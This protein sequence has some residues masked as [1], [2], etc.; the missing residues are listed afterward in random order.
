M[1][2]GAILW[3]CY[4]VGSFLGR[5]GMSRVYG[6]VRLADHLPVALKVAE[7]PEDGGI[8]AKEFRLLRDLEHSGVVKVLEYREMDGLWVL[9]ME[10]LEGEDL[11]RKKNRQEYFSTEQIRLWGISLICIL[12]YLHERGICYLDL[13]PA[14]VMCR[15][16]GSLV[17]VDF[18]AA[19][20]RKETEGQRLGT[21]GYAAP[22]QLLGRGGDWRSDMYSFGATLYQL[23]TGNLYEGIFP[24]REDFLSPILKRC[25]AKE[26]G[27]RYGSDGELL[28]D[29]L[30]GKAGSRRRGLVSLFRISV[31]MICCGVV[32]SCFGLLEWKRDAQAKEV[33][34]QLKESMD[35]ENLCF[36]FPEKRD[37]YLLYLQKGQ[38]D[39][40]LTG[41][42]E[43][44]FMQLCRQIPREERES[45]ISLLKEQAKEYEVVRQAAKDAGML[46]GSWNFAKLFCLE[47]ELEWRLISM[48]E[49]AFCEGPVD[50]CEYWQLLLEWN[51]GKK[52]SDR[53][54]LR[55]MGLFFGEFQKEEAAG[56]REF[57]QEREHLA[58]TAEWQL[59]EELFQEERRKG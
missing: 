42:E 17:L 26:P 31:A 39:G 49:Q 51:K 24:E 18:G 48:R 44:G 19:F 30:D 23:W 22:E 53:R 8:L 25:L 36:L 12:S 5:G 38:E 35:S 16:D 9:V 41:E 28:R 6:G 20:S 32:W 47:N 21:K 29:L 1:K 4:Q 50:F 27:N 46:Y 10:R 56:F 55:E 14:N 33:E 37:G 40:V 34:V 58:D 11:R 7:N 54:I 15:E 2:E 13:K 52:E 43:A 3:G 45:C 57:W 59:L